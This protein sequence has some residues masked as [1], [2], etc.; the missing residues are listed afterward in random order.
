MLLIKNMLAP[1]EHFAT[2]MIPK[3]TTNS[4]YALTYFVES[5]KKLPDKLYE[6]SIDMATTFRDQINKYADNVSGK[7]NENTKDSEY[8][9]L[10]NRRIIDKLR[11]KDY[12][13]Y[14][15]LLMIGK[16]RT[17]LTEYETSVIR[18]YMQKQQS[19]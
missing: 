14:T 7:N 19:R 17:V 15:Q 8:V 12:A 11:N 3:A 18:Q 5:V 2:D 16:E 1:V 6:S 10:A 9:M 13:L 4:I